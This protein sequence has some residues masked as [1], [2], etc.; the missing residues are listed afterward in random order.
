MTEPRRKIELSFLVVVLV[1]ALAVGVVGCG[2][3]ANQ[4]RINEIQ[5]AR[6]ESCRQTYDGIRKTFLP[7]F[8]PP[9][10]RTAKQKADLAK[11]NRTIHGLKAQCGK[12][13]QTQEAP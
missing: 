4:H 7:F 2:I 1:A 5:D 13:T 11:L 3:R 9:R 10:Q 6:L 8:P 12:Q